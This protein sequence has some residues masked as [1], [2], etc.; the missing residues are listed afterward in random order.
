MRFKSNKIVHEHIYWDQA[1]LLNQIGLLDATNLPI[2]G[3]EQSEKLKELS[4]R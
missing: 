4:S 3:V 1:S 2:K